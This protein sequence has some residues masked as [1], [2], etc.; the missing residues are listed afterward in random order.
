[1]LKWLYSFEPLIWG[2]TQTRGHLSVNCT[3]LCFSC[4]YNSFVRPCFH[5][6][7]SSGPNSFWTSLVAQMV[8]NLPE[9]QEAWVDPLEMI[10]WRKEWQPIPVFLPG[11]YPG[12]RSLAGYSP[13]GRIESDTTEWLTLSL[14]SLFWHQG[15]SH[16]RQ[17]SHRLGG[18][19]SFRMIQAYYTYCVLYFYYYDI[20]STSDHQALDPGGWGPLCYGTCSFSR[21]LSTT[22]PHLSWCPSTC[23][24][25]A[26][27][28]FPGQNLV[29]HTRIPLSALG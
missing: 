1:M 15:Q 19:D 10:P 17:S 7:E 9:M 27:A 23:S 22:R 2:I 12:Q 21:A 16:G 8:K 26:P 18:G 3:W 11:E 28:T 29:H 4:S 20:S 5:V 14:S 6:G 25:L 13:W 24:F